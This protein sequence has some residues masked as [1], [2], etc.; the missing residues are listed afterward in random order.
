MKK[1]ILLFFIV[2]LCAKL[3]A[4]GENAEDWREWALLESPERT[5]EFLSGTR[6][7]GTTEPVLAGEISPKT[8]VLETKWKLLSAHPFSLKNYESR[9]AWEKQVN[10]AYDFFCGWTLPFADYCRKS[11]DRRRFASCDI[12]QK[13]ELALSLMEAAV[14]SSGERSREHW[15]MGAKLFSDLL[16]EFRPGRANFL[17]AEIDK[18]DFGFEKRTQNVF[19]E[20]ARFDYYRQNELQKIL[21][22]GHLTRA[23][24]AGLNRFFKND[25]EAQMRFC[26]KTGI[27]GKLELSRQNRPDLCRESISNYREENTNF[28]QKRMFV[29]GDRVPVFAELP[30]S[31]KCFSEK[32]ARVQ[33]FFGRDWQHAA[34]RILEDCRLDL[35]EQESA[36]IRL[37]QALQAIPMLSG[38]EI[39]FEEFC[40]ENII[41]HRFS[42]GDILLK[43]SVLRVLMSREILKNLEY[44]QAARMYW[45]CGLNLFSELLDEYQPGLEEQLR[46]KIEKCAEKDFFPLAKNTAILNVKF[47]YERQKSIREFLENGFIQT[48][49]DS[50]RYLY[51]NDMEEQRR[52][53][54]TAGIRGKIAPQKP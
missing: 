28:P 23:F 45:E 32:T 22:F 35:T 1:N 42:T 10:E 37:S 31:E 13:S 50:L 39:P 54:D 3:F 9:D 41:R 6:P 40:G 5:R 36:K 8:K 26:A 33:A 34:R 11:G 43:Q 20:R 47:N 27:A 21:K 29:S 15:E 14:R 38:W 17:E 16:G 4:T 48:F 18:T 2:S 53:Y 19:L 12:L 46:E 30:E 52:I 44:P 49:F 24:L 51:G 25:R 7:A